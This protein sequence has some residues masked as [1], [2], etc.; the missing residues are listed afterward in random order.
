MTSVRGPDASRNPE[1]REARQIHVGWE[2]PPL[3]ARPALALYPVL[4]GGDVVRVRFLVRRQSILVDRYQGV[5][6]GGRLMPLK[7]IRH[8]PED[9]RE[10]DAL[11]LVSVLCPPLSW[12][13]ALGKPPLEGYGLV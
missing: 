11:S 5:A 12:S 13:Q 1:V 7:V 10:G 2:D 9:H 4:D 6:D 8:R 3:P